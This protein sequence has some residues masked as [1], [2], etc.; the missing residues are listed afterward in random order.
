M[1]RK[2]IFFTATTAFAMALLS[3]TPA[4]AQQLKKGNMLV[5][6]S[7][8]D[9]NINTG[10]TKYESPTNVTSRYNSKSFG[11][12]LS[13][14][15]GFF[16]SDN[17][18]LGTEVNISLYNSNEDDF[19]STGVKTSDSK[20]RS[21]SIGLSPF[22]R[23]YFPGKNPRSVFYGQLSA[24]FN[25]DVSR[26]QDYVYYNALGAITNK[27]KYNY[28]KKPSNYG[29]NVKVGWNRFLTESIALNMDLGYEFRR[30]TQTSTYTNTPAVG[31][32]T[33]ST[34]SKYTYNRS[35]VVW[36]LGFTMFIPC[37]KKK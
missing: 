27:F 13:P 8:G 18:V 26:K 33:T 36:G 1:K 6:T 37:K 30:N 17:F 21:T 24:G 12:T 35:G 4:E 29:G 5:E 2:S 19:N 11:I 15:V 10:K 7:M 14:R 9:I 32:A 23:L 31:P 16:L 22:A 20:F 25:T 34:S 28:S 3:V